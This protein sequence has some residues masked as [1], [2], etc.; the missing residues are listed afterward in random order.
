MVRNYKKRT[1]R[2][3]WSEGNM[4]NAVK[5]VQENKIGMRTAARMWSVPKS[6]LQ[7]RLKGKVAMP[8]RLGR[9]EVLG[10]KAE[11]ELVYTY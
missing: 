10:H 8:K 5:E 2:G 6:S 3:S 4:L 11:K 1:S 7:R 9:H